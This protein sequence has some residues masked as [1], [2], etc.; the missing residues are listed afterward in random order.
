MK[1]NNLYAFLTMLLIS[2]SVFAAGLSGTEETKTVVRSHTIKI[3][4]CSSSSSQATLTFKWPTELS[5]GDDPWISAVADQVY[6]VNLYG[7]VGGPFCGEVTVQVP[8][9]K[10]FLLEVRTNQ[11]G[12]NSQTYSPPFFPSEL[13]FNFAN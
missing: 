3:S 10:E 5:S 1:K 13:N 11:G 8:A 7:F 6:T 4:V 2:T 9:D 12:Y